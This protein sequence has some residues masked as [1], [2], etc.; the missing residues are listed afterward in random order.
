MLFS[1][2][3]Y[4]FIEFRCSI[5]VTLHKIKVIRRKVKVLFSLSERLTLLY[6]GNF[7]VILRKSVFYLL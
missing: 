3:N 2:K 6:A 7:R 1:E 5:D 4:I